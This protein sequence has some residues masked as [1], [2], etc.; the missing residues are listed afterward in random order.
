MLMR[1]DNPFQQPSPFALYE[2][3][4]TTY[5]L[6][7]LK[8]KAASV[9]ISKRRSLPGSVPDFFLSFADIYI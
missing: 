4:W 9:V 5:K 6:D 3:G 1:L 2:S 7:A 8:S